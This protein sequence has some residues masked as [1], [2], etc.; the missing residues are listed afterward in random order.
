MVAEAEDF[1]IEYFIRREMFTNLYVKE[2]GQESP[3][4]KMRMQHLRDLPDDTLTI[5]EEVLASQ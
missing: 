2:K 4:C 5:K 1:I 3:Y